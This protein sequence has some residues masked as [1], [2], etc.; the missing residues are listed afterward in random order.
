[1]AKVLMVALVIILSVPTASA[2]A[3]ESLMSLATVD[4]L[5]FVR[6]LAEARVPAG[7]EIRQSDKSIPPRLSSVPTRERLAQEARVSLDSIAVACNASHR[8]YRATVAAGVVVVRP[9]DHA[10]DYLDQMTVSGQLR[11]RGLMAFAREVFAPLQPTLGRQRAQFG[12]T[13]SPVGVDVDRGDALELEIDAQGLTV[14]EILNEVA[15]RAPGHAWLFVT[16]DG[17]TPRI[18][19]LGFLHNYGSGTEQPLGN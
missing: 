4:P 1:M 7:L 9:T 11:A 17:D 18:A 10:V 8:A 6:V 14:L 13:P 5:T 2:Q 16:R 3:P 12:S 15:R 19:S